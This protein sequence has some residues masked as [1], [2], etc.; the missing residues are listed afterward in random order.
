MSSSFVGDASSPA[1]H[2]RC[3]EASWWAPARC[4]EAVAVLGGVVVGNGIAA[5]VVVGKSIVSRVVVGIGIASRV[6]LP[7]AG[8]S[9]DDDDD[10]DVC[11]RCTERVVLGMFQSALDGAG[12]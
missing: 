9:D 6:G 1:A 4:S 7:E 12:R 10:D 11:G 5:R 3:S 2:A 8:G